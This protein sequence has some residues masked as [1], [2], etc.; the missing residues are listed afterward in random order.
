[1]K[2]IRS[3]FTV[4]TVIA[5]IVL[6]RPAGHKSEVSAATTCSINIQSNPG[7]GAKVWVYN[8]TDGEWVC[9]GCDYESYNN[10]VDYCFSTSW[11]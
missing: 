8:T 10:S 7:T 4:V 11:I 5:L 9:E 2:N 1:M 6:T 3:I